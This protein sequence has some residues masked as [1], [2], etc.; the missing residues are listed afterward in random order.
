MDRFDQRCYDIFPLKRILSRFRAKSSCPDTAERPA[1]AS[2]AK[3][4]GFGANSR[5]VVESAAPCSKALGIGD[6]TGNRFQI[7]VR[8]VREASTNGLPQLDLAGLLRDRAPLL[9]VRDHGIALRASDVTLCCSFFF[10]A[11][12]VQRHGIV[13]YFGPQRVGRR[14]KDNGV[15]G[16][17]IAAE[18]LKHNWIQCFRYILLRRGGYQL[19]GMSTSA[20]KEAEPVFGVGIPAKVN[21]TQTEK[22]DTPSQ[23][24]VSTYKPQKA[25]QRLPRWRQEER[26]LVEGLGRCGGVINTRTGPLIYASVPQN[27]RR[28]W[29]HALQSAMWNAMASDRMRMLLASNSDAVIVGDLVMD[30]SGAVIE[31]DESIIEARGAWPRIWDVVIPQPG[32]STKFSSVQEHPASVHRLNLLLEQEVSDKKCCSLKLVLSI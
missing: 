17:M 24:T 16:W 8:G 10:F 19:V 1:T 27:I 28:V 15:S 6:L 18:A 11:R 12:F 23:P 32:N 9:A 3:G 31:V 14:S 30:E 13:N 5:I 20:T 25:L 7:T 4:H 22:S 26:R 29:V 21:K 2:K